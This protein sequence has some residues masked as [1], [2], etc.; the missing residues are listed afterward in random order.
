[1][2][3]A[4]AVDLAAAAAEEADAALWPV[5]GA[6]NEEEED[7]DDDD[8]ADESGL[9]DSPTDNCDKADSCSGCWW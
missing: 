6:D 1:M 4:N 5:V 3:A 8:D 9:G 7:D 2:F